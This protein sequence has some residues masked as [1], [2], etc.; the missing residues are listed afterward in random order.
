M[1]PPNIHLVTALIAEEERQRAQQARRARAATSSS[2]PHRGGWR[3]APLLDGLLSTLSIRSPEARSN[4][5]PTD[6]SS[7]AGD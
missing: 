6:G 7:P 2:T 5:L 3:L 1:V 4:R